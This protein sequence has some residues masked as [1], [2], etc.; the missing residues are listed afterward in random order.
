MHI[1]S[2]AQC[3]ADGL[4]TVVINGDILNNRSQVLYAKEWIIHQNFEYGDYESLNDLA[5]IVM[6]EPLTFNYFVQ[7]HSPAFHVSLDI[8]R[9]TELQC[10]GVGWKMFKLNE[11][12]LHSDYIGFKNP[13]H[14]YRSLYQMAYTMIPRLKCQIA[15][16]KVANKDTEIQPSMLCGH[17]YY[18]ELR[19][20]LLGNMDCFGHHGGPLICNIQGRWMFQGV[21]SSNNNCKNNTLP[22]LFTNIEYY[23]DW[24]TNNTVGFSYDWRSLV[25]CKKKLCNGRYYV[26]GLFC[27]KG[28][29][30][31]CAPPNGTFHDVYDAK[32]L[33]TSTRRVWSSSNDGGAGER[34]RGNNVVI[35][36]HWDG[37]ADDL[38]VPGSTSTSVKVD[39]DLL[40]TATSRLE[41][42]GVGGS[43]GTI[44]LRCEATVFR[45]YK[46]NSL[47]LEVRPDSPTP[48]PASVLLMGPSINESLADELQSTKDRL[49][50]DPLNKRRPRRAFV[51]CAQ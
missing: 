33:I 37:D 42:T 12:H 45:L 20:K 17:F 22:T 4:K 41:L 13:E 7:K 5:I 19:N 29:N 44:R 25:W 31:T 34:C 6:A 21:L 40:E 8:P 11:I 23:G 51:E 10:I 48:Q 47:E 26:Y 49:Q 35:S 43:W 32:S 9:E 27:G 36:R 50:Y 2:S 39:E 3:Y 14:G 18:V 16:D 38:H 46:A 30:M 28:I 15:M 24:I 1:L